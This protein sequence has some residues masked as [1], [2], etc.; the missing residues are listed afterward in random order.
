MSSH[1]RG[2]ILAAFVAAAGV[3]E[4]YDAM[5]SL[6]SHASGS[7]TWYVVYLVLGIITIALAAYLF[8]S[9]RRSQS[10]DH[11]SASD[12][13]PDDRDGPQSGVAS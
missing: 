7:N 8:L 1:K 2:Y 12:G 13:E 11:R 6:A 10:R 9:E 4:I 3:Y 5:R